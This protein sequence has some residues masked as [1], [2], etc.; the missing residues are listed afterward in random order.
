MPTNPGF[1]IPLNERDYEF[2][3]DSGQRNIC[4]SANQSTYTKAPWWTCEN[5]Q[6]TGTIDAVTA[7]VGDTV[8]IQVGV[9]EVDGPGTT[10][11]A[12][13]LNVQAWVCYPNT[14]AGRASATLV[15][16]SMQNNAFAL[17]ASPPANPVTVL[18]DETYQGSE[19]FKWISLSAWT[20]T[21]TDF[22]EQATNGGHCCIIANASGLANA[23]EEG[24]DPVGV[25]I[26]DQSQLQSDIDICTNFQQAQRNV[27]IVPQK[28]GMRAGRGFA[29][30]SGAPQQR[31][32]SRTTVE[33][34]AIDQG[35]AVDPVLHKVLV[36]GPYAGLTLKPAASPP[37]SLRLTRHDHS[38][39]N[40][41]CKIVHEAE[42]L[43][44]E[45]FGLEIHP[46]GGGHRLHLS[47][48][49]QGLQPLRL[50]AEFDPSEEP[51]TVHAID[52][53]QTDANG[54]RGGIRVGIVVVP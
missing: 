34:T 20:P 49:P 16:P 15:V 8:V 45:L 50:E 41:L 40:W 28:K 10:Y 17:F 29:F 26:S 1:M 47:L 4:T 39:N 14:V 31:D 9:Q 42:E 37:K 7:Q 19:S 54:A 36:G 24:G 33:V 51:G 53:T 38:W 25:N 13:V 32:K 35:G 30:L 44:E 6:F 18:D 2:P 46:F 21:Q 52:I 23:G 3:F 11:V 5:I 27:L 48:P 43:V 12:Q 22:L